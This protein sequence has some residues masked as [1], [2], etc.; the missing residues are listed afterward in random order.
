MKWTLKYCNLV[1][2]LAR[3]IIIDHCALLKFWF[4]TLHSLSTVS[5]LN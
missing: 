3:G 5:C 1:Y 4:V 2:N